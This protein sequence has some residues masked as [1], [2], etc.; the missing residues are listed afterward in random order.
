MFAF[1][2]P[3]F[4]GILHLYKKDKLVLFFIAPFSSVISYV[5][6][7]VAYYF[8]FWEVTPFP[9]HKNLASIP[10]ELGFYPIL[11]CYFIFF[12]RKSKNPYFVVVFMSLLTTL[13]ELLCFYLEW[14]VYG[15]GW[16]IYLTFFSY[17]FPFLIVYWYYKCLIKQF[18]LR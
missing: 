4:I 15:N 6:N 12:I 13:L 1:V 5:V 7:T 9:K 18:I 14:I 11:T 16:N 17:L 8:G 3:W 2:L 10:F